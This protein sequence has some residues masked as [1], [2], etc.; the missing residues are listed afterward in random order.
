MGLFSSAGTRF[1]T[2]KSN[3]HRKSGVRCFGRGFKDLNLPL[4]NIVALLA[5]SASHCSLFSHLTALPFPAAG[6]GK[7]LRPGTRACLG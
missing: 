2:Y 4:E 7:A 6:S 5:W 3:G 1:V